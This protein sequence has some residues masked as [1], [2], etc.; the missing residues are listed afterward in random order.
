ML[1]TYFLVLWLNCNDK[2]QMYN[3]LEDKNLIKI[4]KYL[5]DHKL[6]D[7]FIKSIVSK[8]DLYKEMIENIKKYK[9]ETK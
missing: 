1:L 7:V 8:D 2:R 6:Y 3:Y 5:K 4:Y 9:K